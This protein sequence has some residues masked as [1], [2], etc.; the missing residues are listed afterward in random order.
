MKA[1]RTSN[2]WIGSYILAGFAAFLAVVVVLTEEPQWY[3]ESPILM[4]SV[5]AAICAILLFAIGE[6]GTIDARLA[7]RLS[8]QG[9]PALGRII[10]DLGGYGTATIIPPDDPDGRVMQFIP[11]RPDGRPVAT[12]GGGFSYHHGQAGTLAPPL[13]APLLDSL[14]RE[15]GLS[16][17][18]EES[19]LMGAIREVCEDLISVA[20]RVDATSE[21]GVATI[22]LHNYL[23]Y[24]GCVSRREASPE[25]C[26]LCPCSICSLIG[27]MIAEGLACEVSLHQV[28]LDDTGRSPSMRVQ[29]ALA[30]TAQSPSRSRL[31]AATPHHRYQEVHDQSGRDQQQPENECGYP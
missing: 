9:I 21:G 8:M 15:N 11:I 13:A 26:T 3:L 7:S 27:C 24:S 6:E 25:S 4:L 31:M 1:N 29:F 14:K 5:S 16:L 22:H 23:L 12:D 19:L 2:F 20:D 10:Q 28:V 30:A 17:P 18:A